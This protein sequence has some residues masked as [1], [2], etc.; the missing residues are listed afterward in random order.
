M[1]TSQLPQPLYT[2][3]HPIKRNVQRTLLLMGCMGLY[4]QPFSVQDAQKGLRRG[5][6]DDIFGRIFHRRWFIVLVWLLILLVGLGDYMVLH[7]GPWW[8]CLILSP[9]C[10]YHLH[11][12]RLLH[13]C[14]A[15]MAM[16]FTLVLLLA[17]PLYCYC[18]RLCITTIFHQCLATTSLMCWLMYNYHFSA[19]FILASPLYYS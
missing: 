6:K 11:H 5:S 7:G 16:S 14:H 12:Q 9:L 19:V 17:S 10:Y 4:T 13:L 1:K 15:C 18:L 2:P 8:M 3:I